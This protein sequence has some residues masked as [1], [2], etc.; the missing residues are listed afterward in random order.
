MGCVS[1]N[2]VCFPQ[3]AKIWRQTIRITSK[4]PRRLR[5]VP[6]V[7]KV[8]VRSGLRY[9]YMMA[10]DNDEFFLELV[11]TLFRSAQGCTGAHE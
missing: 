2:A 10:D 8:F 3:H 11:S 5:E 9:D 4:L 7:K 1:R 6:G